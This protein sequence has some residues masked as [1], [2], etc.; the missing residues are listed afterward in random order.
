MGSNRP[1]KVLGWIEVNERSLRLVAVGARMHFE[2]TFV[3]LAGW[4]PGWVHK[5]MRVQVI[6]QH[7]GRGATH[8]IVDGWAEYRTFTLDDQ[9]HYV[10]D[11]GDG[12]PGINA[13][14]RTACVAI[15]PLFVD[16]DE[17]TLCPLCGGV[18]RYRRGYDYCDV[19]GHGPVP[20]RTERG[21]VVQYGEEINPTW[22][23][24]GPQIHPWRRSLGVGGL[25]AD[26]ATEPTEGDRC[27]LC[28]RA[29][30]VWTAGTLICP[31]CWHRP[32]V[33]P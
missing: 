7:Q 31:T 20:D 13:A 2:P 25:F 33:K 3:R 18:T 8:V 6:Y 23:H 4:N 21:L 27:L 24:E 19:S 1:R 28:G 15:L 14:A 12:S 29:A 10:E 16:E 17:Q 30:Y 26:K 5:T 11:G 32:L 22:I 9:G